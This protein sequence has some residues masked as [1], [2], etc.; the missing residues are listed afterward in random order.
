LW[1]DVLD[2]VKAK[3]RTAHALMMSS[4]LEGLEGSTLS[5]SFQPPKLAQRFPG[6]VCDT[7][8]GALKE[9]VGVDFK[10]VTMDGK[11]NGKPPASPPPRPSETADADPAPAAPSVVDVTE[12]EL[13]DSEDI[14]DNGPGGADEAAMALLKEGLG[15]QVIGE[16]DQT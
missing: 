12:A 4:E 9:V 8:T 10:I 1:G 7:V 2:A 5:I 13:E 15:A 6:D 16:I 14:P 11:G 3:S